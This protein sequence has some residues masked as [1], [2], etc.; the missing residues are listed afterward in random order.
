MFEG[1]EEEQNSGLDDDDV[2][3]CM[4]ARVFEY[5]HLGFYVVSIVH[6]TQQKLS[7]SLF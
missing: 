1:E 3:E 2:C 7:S 4:C 5:E 6:H